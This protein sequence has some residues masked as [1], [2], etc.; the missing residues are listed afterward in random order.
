MQRSERRTLNYLVH[1][2]LVAAGY[3]LTAVTFSEEETG[4]VTFLCGSA[5]TTRAG[6]DD[7]VV[8]ALCHRTCTTAP[9]WGC[10]CVA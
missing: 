2:Y 7:D 4:Q 8:T 9:P 6:V 10:T 1:S 3:K 5:T